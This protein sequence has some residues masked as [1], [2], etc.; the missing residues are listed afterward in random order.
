MG[1]RIEEEGS[2]L[3]LNGEKT[4]VSNV[5]HSSAALV[6]TKF[7]EGL[8]SVVVEFDW[9]GVSVEQHYENMADHHQTHFVMED[10]TVPEVNVVTRGPDG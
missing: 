6:W 1:T 2:E 3:V 4:W 7:P 9:D 10:V 5:E 8:G